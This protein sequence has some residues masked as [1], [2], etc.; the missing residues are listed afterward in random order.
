V[1]VSDLH[2]GPG[3][4]DPRF[5]GIEDFYAGAEWSAFLAREG[6]RGP[7]DV[8]IAGDFIE[9]WQIAT[10]LH[11]LPRPEDPSQPPSGPVLGADQAFARTAIDLVIAGG[12]S[13]P[14]ARPAYPG[15]FRLLRDQCSA[16]GTPFHFKQWGEWTPGE[17]VERVRGVVDT[18][19]LDDD[20]WRIYPL[21][22]ATDDGHIDDQPD[23]YRVG[24]KAAGRL[25]DGIEHNGVPHDL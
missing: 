24:K 15:W 6:A 18:A 23:L 3:T 12:E 7:T 1:I 4:T 14:R 11:A 5:A 22:L 8:V 16:A 21:N 19:F 2:L 25:L 13:G 10:A 9:F 17:N 20:G